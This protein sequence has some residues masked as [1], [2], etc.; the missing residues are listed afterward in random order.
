MTLRGKSGTRRHLIV[1]LL[2]LSLIS[3]TIYA[4][5]CFARQNHL[6]ESDNTHHAH[7]SIDTDDHHHDRGHRHDDA[8]HACICKY[9]DLLNSSVIRST[10]P[11]VTTVISSPPLPTFKEVFS[12]TTSHHFPRH[13]RAPPAL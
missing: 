6:A 10:P 2:C 9:S 13:T 12:F 7:D 4:S 5:S 11:T 8:A 1:L 3:F